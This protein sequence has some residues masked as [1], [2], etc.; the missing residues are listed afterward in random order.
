M[1][2]LWSGALTFGLV[3]IPVKLYSAV[4]AKER[5]T[6]RLLHKK[7]LAPVRYERVSEKTGRKVEW[8]DIVKGYE[9][10]K[11]KFVAVTDED[12]KAAAIE[13]SKTIE[14]LDFVGADEVDPRYFDTPYY[15]V[16]AKGGEKA[17]ALLREAIEL[18]SSVGIGR[19]SMRTN[20]VHL[21]GV[22]AVDDALLLETMRFEH[23]LVAPSEFTFPAK[24]N[25]R[26]Q[27]L[28]MAQMLVENLSQPFDPSKYTDEYHTKLM[29]I[30]RAKMKGK[31]IDIPVPEARESTQVV[32]LMARLQESL[33]MG[34]KHG[35]KR[36]A[37]KTSRTGRAAAKRESA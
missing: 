5:V 1:R 7:D 31:E 21:A 17:Y 36:A 9:Y 20:T 26:P 34:K 12:F 30:I 2:P 23:E 11:G 15:L 32:D 16:P 14:I 19:I 10:T 6:F 13:S 18:T 33:E 8:E 28:K 3:N 22:K 25:V 27:E 29:K 4:K 37:R 24:A 35:A